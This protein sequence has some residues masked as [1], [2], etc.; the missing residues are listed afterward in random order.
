MNRTEQIK[1]NRIYN[2]DCRTTLKKLIKQ[3]KK[4]DLVL[5]SPPYNISSGSNTKGSVERYCSKYA[6]Y[7]DHLSND[8]YVSFLLSCFKLFSKVIKKNGVVLC[9]ISYSSSVTA[10]NNC[11]EMLRLI[12]K[13]T[14]ETD[15]MVA[16]LICWKKNSALP[17]NRSSNKLTRICEFVFV[18]CRKSEYLSFKMNKKVTKYNEKTNMRFYEVLYNYIEAKNNDGSC[19]Y[20]KATYSTEFCEKLLNIYARLQNGKSCIVYDPFMGTGTTA[21]ACKKLGISFLGSEIS[22]DQVKFSFERI[23][24]LKDPCYGCGFG[25]DPEEKKQCKEYKKWLK[26]NAG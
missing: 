6:E 5:T 9:N 24:K 1:L 20:N 11:T 4:V 7:N 25:C 26:V 15:L 21:C 23:K 22:K 10:N 19:E 16:D 12:Y 3:N 13:V 17:D 18:F 8:E 2:E 14:E